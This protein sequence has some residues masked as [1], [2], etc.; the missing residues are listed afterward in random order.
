M[1][2]CDHFDHNGSSNLQLDNRTKITRSLIMTGHPRHI[3]VADN[4][5]QEVW[6]NV[7]ADNT[8]CVMVTQPMVKCHA[9]LMVQME[10][11]NTEIFL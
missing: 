7:G 11:T 10:R 4:S 3:R 2:C 1:L 6:K 9:H 5:L 8:V